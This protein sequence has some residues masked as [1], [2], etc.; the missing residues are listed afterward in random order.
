MQNEVTITLDGRSVVLKRRLAASRD[1]NAAFG[2]FSAAFQRLATFDR[3]AY[4]AVIAHG[5][6]D[7]K[8]VDEAVFNTDLATLTGPLTEYVTILFNGGKSAKAAEGD[9]A[10]NG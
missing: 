9:N 3:A 5:A 8:N 1:I 2:S 10:G 7:E 6:V 4:V